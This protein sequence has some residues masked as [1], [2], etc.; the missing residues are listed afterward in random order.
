MRGIQESGTESVIRGPR[1]SFTEN[2][3][4]NTALIRRRIKDPNL[5]MKTSQVGRVSQTAVTLVYING[6]VNEKVLSKIESQLKKIDIDAIKER[7]KIEEL[8]QDHKL[9]LFPTVYT[10][11]RPDVT[12]AGIL[13]GRVAIIV[14]GTPFVMLA[15]ALFVQ[16]F[17]AAEDYYLAPVYSVITRFLRYVSFL[18]LLLATSTYIAAISFHQELIP[19]QLLISFATQRENVPFPVVVEALLLMGTYEILREAIIRMPKAVGSA[20]SI[21]GALVLGDAAIQ[22]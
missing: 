11:E 14:D 12:A 1:E 6:I 18:I 2:L 10:T 7:G 9:S 13:E 8:I 19:T 16:F 3:R 15:P 5:R 20:V 21:V 17:Q 22:A 4:T